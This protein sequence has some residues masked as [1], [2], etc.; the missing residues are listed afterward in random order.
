[1]V[2]MKVSTPMF[3]AVTSPSVRMRPRGSRCLNTAAGV[4]PKSM[5]I[6]MGYDSPGMGRRVS[7]AMWKSAVKDFSY[8]GVPLRLRPYSERR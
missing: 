1:M 5:P 3:S 4:R 6:T 7:L 8:T 2:R